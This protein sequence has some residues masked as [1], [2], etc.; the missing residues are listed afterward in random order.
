MKPLSVPERLTKDRF[1]LDEEQ[2]HIE[3][4]QEIAKASGTG[5][6]LVACCPAHVYTG[7]RRDHLRRV[8]RLPGVR[9]LPRDCCPWLA[10]MAL[11]PRR[12]RRPVREG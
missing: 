1:L 2:C 5:K 3:V 7:T 8:R 10:E 12:V 11:S 4:N 6:L 9:N